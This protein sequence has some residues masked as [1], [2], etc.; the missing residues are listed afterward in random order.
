M[1]GCPD[2]VSSR[3]AGETACTCE[4][5]PN[6]PATSTI[7]CTADDTSMQTD[8]ELPNPMIVWF[9]TVEPA[10]KFS[11]EACDGVMHG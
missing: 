3:R 1:V 8:F 7:T 11:V 10:V 2:R 6:A 9:A 4:D 5:G